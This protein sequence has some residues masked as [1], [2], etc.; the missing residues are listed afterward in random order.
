VKFA[1]IVL[2]AYVFSKPVKA[3]AGSAPN[4][5]YPAGYSGAT[6]TGV[7]EKAEGDPKQV[8]LVYTKGN[9]T[10]RFE[11]RLEADCV[12]KSK[13]GAMHTFT[14]LQVPKDTVLTVFYMGSEKKSNGDKSTQHLVIAISLAEI[15]GKKIPEDQRA[16]ISC[17]AVPLADFKAFH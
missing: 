15:N 7:V 16:V 1:A 10:E 5:F 11:G 4:G 8:N 14:P 9:K 2:I 6:F 17:S 13:D 3:Q 12:W